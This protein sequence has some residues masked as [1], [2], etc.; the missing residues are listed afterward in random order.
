MSRTLRFVSSSLVALLVLAPTVALCDSR[1]DAMPCCPDAAGSPHS[2]PDLDAAPG[3]LECCAVQSEAAFS[4]A[5]Y[6]AMKQLDA[7]R[8][9]P[10]AR[11]ANPVEPRLIGSSDPGPPCRTPRS[12]LQLSSSLLL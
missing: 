10:I 2:G 12:G 9:A 6:V 5:L 11:G 4:P 3:S 8:E 1:A 7:P